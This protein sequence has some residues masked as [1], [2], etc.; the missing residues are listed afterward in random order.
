MWLNFLQQQKAAE[1][2]PTNKPTIS[3]WKCSCLYCSF[4]Q[5]LRVWGGRFCHIH[6][7]ACGGELCCRTNPVLSAAL[8]AF[9]FFFVGMFSFLYFLCLLP[10]SLGTMSLWVISHLHCT[11]DIIVNVD[12]THFGSMCFKM[13]WMSLLLDIRSKF[14][15]YNLRMWR[16]NRKNQCG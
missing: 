6:P 13:W 8:S 10:S 9:H 5:P 12:A 11:S 4:L 1:V 3:P 16:S 2:I 15:P 14:R 7:N